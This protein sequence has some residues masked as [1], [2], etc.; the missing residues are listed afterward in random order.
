MSELAH[1]EP[2][3]KRVPLGAFV[4]AAQH[5]QVVELAKKEDRSVSAVVR[6]ALAAELDRHDEQMT[7]R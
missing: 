1:R 6:R 5:R 3:P 4:D 7:P 2:R